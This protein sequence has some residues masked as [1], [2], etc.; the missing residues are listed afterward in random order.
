MLT[1]VLN[2]LKII[3]CCTGL[4]D[5]V[6][7]MLATE[8]NVAGLA[9]VR[10]CSQCLGGNHCSYLLFSV[11]DIELW[12]PYAEISAHVKEPRSEL[13]FPQFMRSGG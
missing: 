12:A 4:G 9:L 6:G 11:R 8:V 2:I 5:L 13:Y 7:H 10:E 3:C 1:C